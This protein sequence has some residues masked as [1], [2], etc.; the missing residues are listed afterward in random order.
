VRPQQ[1][2][3]IVS[4][5]DVKP[6][7]ARMPNLPEPHALRPRAP[8]LAISGHGGTRRRDHSV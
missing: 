2:P 3:R 7:T 5:P 6:V 8:F 4:P 1:K